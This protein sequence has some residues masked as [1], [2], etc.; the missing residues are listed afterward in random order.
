[1]KK[2]YVTSDAVCP[3][4]HKEGPVIYEDTSFD[5]AFGTEH[6]GQWV[7]ACCECSPPDTWEPE[8]YV[9]DYDPVDEYERRHGL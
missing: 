1:M 4:C 7:M 5:H 8:E 3:E 2:K 6:S 9:P